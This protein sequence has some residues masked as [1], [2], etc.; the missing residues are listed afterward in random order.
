MSESGPLG[1]RIEGEVTDMTL[2]FIELHTDDGKMLLPSNAVL[3]GAIG[4]PYRE[5]PE[6]LWRER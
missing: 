1:G 5:T 2:L 3:G 4:P 6:A